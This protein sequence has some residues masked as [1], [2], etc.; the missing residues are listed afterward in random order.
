MNF[1]NVSS[2]SLR[3]VF[4]RLT[5]NSDVKDL[6]FDNS[7]WQKFSYLGKIFIKKAPGCY[8]A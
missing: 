7:L 5:V 4:H 2:P 8:F 3:F 1:L 6:F